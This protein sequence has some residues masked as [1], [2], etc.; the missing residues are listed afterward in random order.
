[1]GKKSQR[2]NRKQEREARALKLAQGFVLQYLKGGMFDNA[3]P[4]EQHE[5]Y[6][7]NVLINLALY[8]EPEQHFGAA[9]YKSVQ[10]YVAELLD[11]VGNI[12]TESD[13]LASRETYQ[14][15]IL[16]YNGE[17]TSVTKSVG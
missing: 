8:L 15:I 17:R 16:N 2:K 9:A 13:Y 1:M 5:D 12:Q 10:I 14:E 11:L 7:D 3:I 6:L 4:E